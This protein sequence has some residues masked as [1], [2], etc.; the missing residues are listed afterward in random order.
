MLR[1]DTPHDYRLLLIKEA[2]SIL[3]SIV[4]MWNLNYPIHKNKALKLIK[5]ARR[6]TDK[7]LYSYLPLDYLLKN[8]S[9]AELSSLAKA[10]AKELLPPKGV[11]INIKSKE[12]VAEIRYSLL[13]MI[14]L[15]SKLMLGEDNKPEY[16]V[17]IV[18]VEIVSVRKHPK[19]S[20]LLITKG[21]TP[22]YSFT[23][24]T[25]LMD[26][27]KGEVRAAAILPPKNF[28]GVISEAMYCS[29]P[30]PKVWIGKRPDPDLVNTK[31]VAVIVE[32]IIKR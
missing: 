1:T 17:D 27:R 30:I 9:L 11:P 29:N 21:G 15:K 10:L 8:D 31:E 4:H 32:E 23:I 20:K 24:V 14:N 3:E 19:A 18:G 28:F 13:Q 12:L 7:I 25:N 5:S 6:L 2:V 22:S 26:V 16:A